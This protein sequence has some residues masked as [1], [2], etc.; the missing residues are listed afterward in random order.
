MIILLVVALSIHEAKLQTCITPDPDYF[1]DVS[2]TG[3]ELNSIACVTACNLF[4]Y[5]NSEQSA[6]LPN[7]YCF[8][9][10]T[11]TAAYVT[12]SCPTPSTC[13]ATE[14]SCSF[15]IFE[16]S[17]TSEGVKGLTFSIP[18]EIITKQTLSLSPELVSTNPAVYRY[19]YETNVWSA[20]Q[21][22][23]PNITLFAPGYYMVKV[24]AKN[25]LS[26]PILQEKIANVVSNISTAYFDV[27]IVYEKDAIIETNL[28]IVDGSNL[29]INI[30][31][32]EATKT[33]QF[34]LESDV[35]VVMVG[36]SSY[37]ISTATAVPASVM[38]PKIIITPS[39]TF[40]ESGSV[41]ALE[42]HAEAAGTMLFLV[43]RPKCKFCFSSMN[44][45]CVDKITLFGNESLATYSFTGIGSVDVEVI[46]NILVNVSSTGHQL[47]EIHSHKIAVKKGDMFAYMSSA[48]YTNLMYT[49]SSSSSYVYD[50]GGNDVFPGDVF[51]LNSHASI[52]NQ[53]PL[54]K[55]YLA[56]AVVF[57]LPTVSPTDIGEI[58]LQAHISNH[59]GFPLVVDQTVPVQERISG[60]KF[61]MKKPIP[62]DTGAYKS[63]FLWYEM[64]TLTDSGSHIFYQFSIPE[65][66]LTKNSTTKNV[67]FKID[68]VGIFTVNVTASN[69]IN[70][71][72][73][74]VQFSILDKIKGQN[75]Y[76][77][78]SLVSMNESMMVYV[79]VIN[80]TGVTLEV[81]F[82]DG[83]PVQTQIIDDARG[84][85][86]VF[87]NL[88]YTYKSCEK[89]TITA[90]VKNSITQAESWETFPH[91][92]KDTIDVSVLCPLTYVNLSTVPV[93]PLSGMLLL[94]VNKTI[95]LVVD[96][97]SGS[98][99]LYN[100]S[101]GDN[102]SN[103]IVNHSD[104]ADAKLFTKSHK[105]KSIG[106]Y[107][108]K[109]VVS[110]G[111]QEIY[112]RDIKLKVKKCAIPPV[113]FIYGTPQ[114][115][116]TFTR[117]DRR[118]FVA[119]WEFSAECEDSLKEK[120]Q[121]RDWLLEY[122][123]GTKI[124]N[125]GGFDRENKKCSFT[126]AKQMLPA[127]D[128]IL[129]LTMTHVSDVFAY[130]AYIKILQSPLIAGIVNGNFQSI[131]LKRRIAEVN[132]ANNQ[133]Q[134]T[135]YFNFTLDA[136][137]SYDPDERSNG[138]VGSNFIWYCKVLSN[139]S[140]V[141]DS[142][143]AREA[144]ENTTI[145]KYKPNMCLNETLAIVELIG[146]H[147]DELGLIRF[148]TEMFLESV[149][150]Q[151]VVKMKKGNREASF[152][153]E[154]LIT[155]GAPP[156][157]TVN[158]V[159]N[160]KDK[161]NPMEKFALRL[162]CADCPSNER[163]V[164]RWMIK[165][166]DVDISDEFENNLN[167]SSTG[168][169]K[170][171]LVING[172]ILNVSA[173]HTFFLK[174]NFEGSTAVSQYILAIP[175]SSKPYGGDCT[176]NRNEGSARDYFKIRCSGWRNDDQPTTYEFRYDTGAKPVASLSSA[177]E[178]D[179]PLL[180]S[181]SLDQP[182]LSNILL[183][184]G[185]E[186]QN[187]TIN[188]KLR[189]INKYGAYATFDHL[190]VVV[191]PPALTG[192]S[193]TRLNDIFATKPKSNDSQTLAAFVKSTISLVDMESVLTPEETEPIVSKYTG[194]PDVEAED[195]RKKN[196]EE[197]KKQR[198]KI[199][200][201]MVEYLRIAPVKN[202]QDVKVIGD[203]L[204]STTQTGDE[205][206]NEMTKKAIDVVSKLADAL[207]SI[208]EQDV[209]VS[210]LEQSTKS[211][212][213]SISNL[214][215]SDFT[216]ADKVQPTGDIIFDENAPTVSITTTSDIHSTATK[217][218]AQISKE[219]IVNLVASLET[220]FNVVS[221]NKLEG[222]QASIGKTDA[223]DFY[224][225][226]VKATDLSSVNVTTQA[227]PDGRGISYGFELPDSEDMFNVSSQGLEVEVQNVQY[228][229]NVFSWDLNNSRYIKSEVSAL[230]FKSG[231]GE[232]PV[233]S[234]SKPIK[235]KMKNQLENVD[236]KNVSL[237]MPGMIAMKIIPLLSTSCN[238][239]FNVRAL[240]DY[241]NVTILTLYVQYGKPPTK[242]DHDVMLN[243]SYSDG[244]ALTKKSGFVNITGDNSTN[245][246]GMSRERQSN[247]R[248][249]DDNTFLMWGF[250]SST[251]AYLNNRKLY[252]AFSYEGP[253]PDLVRTA[254]L[255]TYDIVESRGAFNFSMKTFCSECRYWDV[256]EEEWSTE[257]CKLDLNST[258]M[259]TTGCM[260]NHLTAFGGFYVAPNPLP[261]PSLALLK[262]GYVLLV[263]VGSVLLLYV[264]GLL[265]ARRADRRDATKIGVCPLLD[266]KPEDTYLYEITVNTGSRRYAG[267]KSNVFF[268]ATGEYSESGIR[269]LKDK[270][271]QTFQR[272][273]SDVFIM[274]AATS[275]GD[276][277]YI[278]VWH[279]N[280]GG[281]WYLRSMEIIDLQTEETYIFIASR[282]LSVDQNDGLTDCLLPVSTKEELTDFNYLFTNKTR[283]DFSDAHLWFSVY[284]RPPRSP[285]TRC[286]RLSV[287]ISLL[288]CSM[289]ASVM[290]YG[291]VP[292]GKPSDENKMGAFT[293]KWS[294][295]FI[296]LVST[297]ITVP[298]NLLLVGIFRSVRPARPDPSLF[299][300]SSEESIDD[301]NYEMQPSPTNEKLIN[302]DV[303][304]KKSSTHINMKVPPPTP[305]LDND[306]D[307]DDDSGKS[308]KKKKKK[309][310]YL[311]HWF[312]YP[313]W[314]LCVLVILGCGFM[315]VWYGMAFGNAKSLD[316]L[317]S[318]S[319]S[320]VQDVL[321]LQPMKVFVMAL[322]IALVVKKLDEEEKSE[323]EK[324]VKTLAQNE[325]WLHKLTKETSLFDRV[326]T[327]SLEPP[328]AGTL[329]SMR[330]LR[331][332]EAKM[333]AISRE[334][335]LYLVFT[336]VV[337][338]IGFL[339]RDHFA[340]HQTRDIE[341]LLRVKVRPHSKFPNT[342]V[343]SEVR[344]YQ[345]FWPWVDEM[346]LQEIYP[347]K[348]YNLSLLYENTTNEDFPGKLYLNDLSSKIVNGVRLRQVRVKT[349]SC[350]MPNY[351]KDI[352]TIDCA[353]SYGAA[354]EEKRDFNYNWTKPTTFK[355]NINP[356]NK[357]WRY[358]TWQDLDAYPI[359]AEL[360]TYY[361]GGYVVELF[362][363]WNNKAVLDQLKKKRWIDRHSRAVI[364]E[365][366][367]YNAGTNYFDAV[368]IVFEFPPS[369]GI[370]HYQSIVTF[371]LYRYT[372]GYA[373]FTIICEVLFLLFMLLFLIRET[374]LLYRT[375][376]PYF[377]EFW[378]LVELS[379]F[380][381]S[382]L[383]VVFYF[384]RDTMA[385]DLL[386]RL[387]DKSPNV[388]INFQ[389][390]AYWDLVFTYIVALICF[391]VT[392]KFIKLLRFNK[393]I[394]MLSSTLR[395][396]WYPLAMFGILFFIIV[397]AVVS[398]TSIIFGTSLYGYRNN[399]KTIASII[400]L[401]L[402]KFSYHQFESTNGVLGPIFFFSFNVMVNWIV[403][404]MFVSIL[405]DVFAD[406]QADI[407][408]Q[409]NEYEMLD[410][411]TDHIK[412]W[413][414]LGVKNRDKAVEDA[415]VEDRPNE[416]DSEVSVRTTVMSRRMEL[417]NAS[418]SSL[419]SRKSSS[420]RRYS[421]R[422]LMGSKAWK[423]TDVLNRDTSFLLDD[424]FDEEEIDVTVN[425]FVNCVN[426][427]YF[428]DVT[429]ATKMNGVVKEE[430]TKV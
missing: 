271:R 122:S 83:S 147:K 238:F 136:S 418:R 242:K 306:D 249:L 75:I 134:N 183:P 88:T 111:I 167:F 377:K 190:A 66:N 263:V 391:F 341:E 101:W 121:L 225:N 368:T 71:E 14:D 424:T 252:F 135:T 316:W 129:T 323:I 160:C 26:E 89:F 17:S 77:S 300:V 273:S 15:E 61:D 233:K 146:I 384:Y 192:N 218:Q 49:S 163:L 4:P 219:N 177:V 59:L 12:T 144:A 216:A 334:L 395:K 228:A 222:E 95:D 70:S 236:S 42:I 69:L 427:L 137:I 41:T 170:T 351:V 374:R 193:S 232:L 292:D 52:L 289:V 127:G 97:N 411:M 404:N 179:Y 345:D 328:D 51:D 339:T 246:E 213:S 234:T 93:K 107:T 198:K 367:L 379:N 8:C 32:K 253:M 86:G 104:L 133:T 354:D 123:N 36:L 240:N 348:W 363:K 386:S 159:F 158:C 419:R 64:D 349:E 311:P 194:L 373:F 371:K 288:L 155:A 315:V 322:F 355:E 343:F 109:T 403:M 184:L 302:G 321:L 102:S 422:G 376:L 239:L 293:F 279:D 378:N 331:L 406:V 344:S 11:S 138:I 413:I 72:N 409:D 267:T 148:N 31:F 282:W 360:E 128:Y 417:R 426:L 262:E 105:Y 126:I 357:P 106:E 124:I 116:F 92:H 27:P 397:A 299:E 54:M 85:D 16:I 186:S 347:A 2:F 25:L 117:G 229:N 80:G 139:R 210:Y 131:P 254:N 143:K 152:T 98:F 264:V 324:Q 204:T 9:R 178:A 157:V 112:G 364:A 201:E 256:V 211:M 30:T 206:S 309:P 369:G 318:I 58:E 342:T 45:G 361:G 251:H 286:Q 260:C 191:N 173:N 91:P 304:R 73:A 287:A 214:M 266:N 420:K 385:R 281:G 168:V 314:I 65:L 276:I 182:E 164:T 278:R 298:V 1:N 329:Q 189:I 165:R 33:H 414:G 176:V 325:K 383:A 352:M 203:A 245:G 145:V 280:S 415:W 205:I 226:K 247:I 319:I 221:K 248:I 401:L 62:A 310:F 114:E 428:D 313:A 308:K 320:L 113:N 396:A 43:L 87:H 215:K 67:V 82:G 84:A 6:V 140:V 410:F 235:I 423:N 381:L 338:L 153:Q 78:N 151:F 224:L 269:R 46:Q 50:R 202:I 22:P 37:E 169:D 294:Q 21:S 220:Y 394:S 416:H 326:D 44:C 185:L 366:A 250:N 332:K 150:Y 330:S 362:P 3:F 18:D 421:S 358:Q 47:L 187:Y 408:L 181:N 274:S 258:S 295:V 63:D 425:K 166:E 57:Q 296:A 79:K 291:A 96:L 76:V 277:S 285:F 141:I 223:F 74:S 125:T 284:A 275:L 231:D 48:S 317:A 196:I 120:F 7:S 392:L 108:I 270:E 382:V 241:R 268:N 340:Y 400:S 175:T 350:V 336:I 212:L 305:P 103:T 24:E 290:F 40:K 195:E 380:I 81:D 5:L 94:E 405:N 393:R 142:T 19:Q 327:T 365:F 243:I 180:N 172:N 261:T 23:L 171:S 402:G 161:I 297:A 56:K 154:V 68:Q 156:M 209:G 265:F 55:V 13:N 307:D 200:Q 35:P 119:T 388:F 10:N 39:L 430:L 407:D 255:Y 429:V 237:Y 60:L 398:S 34:N 356:S 259:E 110:N 346:L 387:P 197:Q 337:F 257:G 335:V 100:I 375:G 301:D 353:D 230:A 174:V 244:I 207:K 115:P 28:I 283:R 370:I 199:R 208:A 53:V 399:L 188:L 38:K 162:R 312:I 149:E 389:F 272:S 217:N 333:Y 118:E 99:A 20:Y 412:S 29:T 303:T 372:S 359:W 390:A 227:D 90:K 130:R 132:M